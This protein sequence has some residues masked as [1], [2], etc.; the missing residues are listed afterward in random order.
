[1]Y[2]LILSIIVLSNTMLNTIDTVKC[3]YEK[4]PLATELGKRIQGGARVKDLV[5]YQGPLHNL[6]LPRIAE[7]Q[8]LCEEYKEAIAIAYELHKNELLAEYVG[9]MGQLMTQEEKKEQ[10]RLSAEEFPAD[11]Q[12]RG[13]QL[14]YHTKTDVWFSVQRVQSVIIDLPND[15]E[16]D[17]YI[18]RENDR[19]KAIQVWLKEARIVA[20]N[21][22][23]VKAL[24]VEIKDKY[25]R[26][27]SVQ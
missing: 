25:I 4:N 13:R 8:A 17:Q 27:I 3:L 15:E 16:I 18:A 19:I 20:E 1:M 5:V 6:S 12:I 11:I 24:S 10:K 14:S 21:K 23:M 9:L 22:K 26:Q 7:I 2:Y